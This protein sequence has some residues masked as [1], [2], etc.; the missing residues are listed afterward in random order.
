MNFYLISSAASAYKYQINKWFC[1]ST[2]LH[3]F[4]H[5]KL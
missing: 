1:F 5:P 4:V 2:I 3:Y